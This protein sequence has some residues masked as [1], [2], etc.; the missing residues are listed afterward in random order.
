MKIEGF[1]RGDNNRRQKHGIS[2]CPPPPL[3]RRRLPQNLRFSPQGSSLPCSSASCPPLRS[4][5]SPAPPLSP[6]LAVALAPLVA[7]VT[8][9]EHQLQ[10]TA[11]H[12]R[13]SDTWRRG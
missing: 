3:L 9:G 11:S 12:S 5:L 4:L 10:D 13:G 8:V 2:I 1:W 6:E 7:A